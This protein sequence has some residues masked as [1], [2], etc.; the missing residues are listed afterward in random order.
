MALS[1]IGKSQ[2]LSILSRLKQEATSLGEIHHTNPNRIKN[3]HLS[4]VFR[5][6]EAPPLPLPTNISEIFAN[7]TS[8]FTPERARDITTPVL[9]YSSSNHKQFAA[10][11]K[12]SRASFDID[13]SNWTSTSPQ[14]SHVES[15][16]CFGAVNLNSS[17]QTNVPKPFNSTGKCTYLN[18]PGGQWVRNGTYIADSQL[19]ERD[20]KNGHTSARNYSTDSISSNQTKSSESDTSKIEKAKLILTKKERFRIVLKDYGKTVT[21]FH[22]TIS[23][24][25]LGVCYVAVSS[26]VDMTNLASVM[27]ENNNELVQKIMV[28]SSTFAVAYGVHKLMAPIRLGITM[29]VVPFLIYNVRKRW[30][31]RF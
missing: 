19:L 9:L 15:Y 14:D 22:I 21:I 1:R 13:N 29:T 12:G 6:P 27:T 23:L 3:F 4:R 25:S 17:M 10:G 8:R 20:N 5:Y 24:I 31:V 2:N 16:D 28:N 26:G 7:E 18:M 30:L 11:S